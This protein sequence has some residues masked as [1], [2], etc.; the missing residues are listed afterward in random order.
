MRLTA[1][2]PDLLITLARQPAAQS[3]SSPSAAAAP[4]E[5]SRHR[6]S[7][8]ATRRSPSALAGRR[9]PGDT[10]YVCPGAVQPCAGRAGSPGHR[11]PGRPAGAPCRGELGAEVVRPQPNQAFEKV[12]YREGPDGFLA[13][14]RSPACPST[15]SLLL[16]DPLVLVCEGLEKPG[17]LGR[18]CARP[19]PPG[20]RR[21]W[22]PTRS[23]TGGTRTWC[24]RARGRSSPSRSRPR[25]RG[26]ARLVAAQRHPAGRRR[27]PTRT[28][29]HRRGLPGRGGRRGG[30]REGGP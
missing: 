27:R 5:E 16:A 17:N 20:W 4:R 29:A 12:A 28:R 2:V 8:R 19:M 22:P 23:P 25:A 21:S 24:A 7:S 1:D 9:P 26:G 3:P 15:T 10:V 11:P 14:V 6:P 18:S 13:V 30:H